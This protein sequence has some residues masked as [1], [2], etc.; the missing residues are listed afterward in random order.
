[1][2]AAENQLE[3]KRLVLFLLSRYERAGKKRVDVKGCKT[4]P[5]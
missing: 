5:S 4:A 3:T 1:M 2:R